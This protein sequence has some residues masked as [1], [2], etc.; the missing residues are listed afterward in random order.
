VVENIGLIH[1]HLFGSMQRH[2]TIEQTHRILRR[3]NEDLENKQYSPAALLDIPQAFNKV[4]HT[5]LLYKLRRPLPLN[6][7]LIL[8]S[9]LHTG[10][11]LVKVETEY[12]ELSPVNSG[13]PQGSV[14]RTLLYLPY[15]EDLQASPQ[16]TTA[17]FAD[18]TAVLATDSDRAIDSQKLQANLSAIQI[19][20][21]KWRRKANGSNSVHVTFSIK[22]ETCPPVHINKQCATSPQEEDVK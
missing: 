4:W 9:Y 7:F 11:F 22:R 2:F 21:K 10:H 14:I 17:T 19:W 12:T 1:N 6:D 8:K 20:F 16:S 15:T 18:D 13:I 5:G 3:I